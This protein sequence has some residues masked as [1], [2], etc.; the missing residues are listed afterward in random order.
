[1]SDRLV[2]A[3]SHGFALA[4][5]PYTGRVLGRM[6]LPDAAAA[7]PIVANETLYFLTD[8]AEVVALR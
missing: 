5:S 4:V 7:A 3:S 6:S 1:M 2:L 8:E